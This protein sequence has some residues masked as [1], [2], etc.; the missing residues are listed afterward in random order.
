[1]LVDGQNNATWWDGNQALDAGEVRERFLG[2]KADRLR[3]VH[4]G[5]PWIR[6]WNAPAQRQ[7]W[8]VYFHHIS[9]SFDNV[10]PSPGQEKRH[11][12]LIR[13]GES[14][15]LL[16]Q[17]SPQ[18][19]DAQT[20]DPTRIYPQ[21]NLVHVDLG[22]NGKEGAISDELTAVLTNSSPGFDHYVVS[23]NGR[24]AQHRSNSFPWRLTPGKNT[25]VVRSVNQAGVA[26]PPTRIDV[27]YHPA[28]AATPQRAAA[29]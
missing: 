22:S 8:I 18:L 10:V 9:Y 21:L 24:S 19:R 23:E 17:G 2:G 5:S 6:S 12:Q 28:S 27:A 3:M 20:Q 16:F 26:G 13:H 1:V 11:V 15:E 25:L 29:K 7:E 4:H 14:H